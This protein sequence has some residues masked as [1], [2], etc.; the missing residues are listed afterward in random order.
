MLSAGN[1][2]LL[3]LSDYERGKHYLALGDYGLA[4]DAFQNALAGDAGSVGAL[5]GLAVAYDRLGRPDAAKTILEQAATRNPGSPETLNNLAYFYLSHGDRTQALAYLSR[6]QSALADAKAPATVAAVVGNNLALAQ[7]PPATV[8]A[9]RTGGQDAL[10]V[11]LKAVS[12]KRW[13]LEADKAAIR[14]T[15]KSMPAV[16][17]LAPAVRA[18]EPLQ[19]AS[20]VAPEPMP[21]TAVPIR[22]PASKPK[23]SSPDN[24]AST[25]GG[26]IHVRIA[27][28][29]GHSETASKLGR[30]LSLKGLP[31]ARL[32]S[33]ANGP[34]KSMIYYSQGLK[35]Q[36]EAIAR[37]LPGHV[38]AIALSNH[39]Q[40]VEL[41]LAPDLAA[42]DRSQSARRT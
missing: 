28:R 20:F 7:V 22:L 11:A 17:K 10:P 4:V 21:M 41:V 1:K 16:P 9:S 24:R 8:V 18:A 34:G 13:N 26:K 33:T 27:Y 30:Y 5:N 23:P 2:G 35:P 25:V 15:P 31:A 40:T 6:A 37:L 12:L 29:A 36:A 19:P 14:M 42:F 3:N 38:R 32:I 39:F